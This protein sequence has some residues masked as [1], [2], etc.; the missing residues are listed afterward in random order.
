[1]RNPR[2]LADMSRGAGGRAASSLAAVACVALVAVAG[3][4]SRREL[5]V[6]FA[7]SASAEDHNAARAACSTAAP[8]ASPEPAPSAST[9]GVT[10]AYDVRFRVDQASDR[11]LNQLVQ[12]LRG[13]PGVAGIE[14]PQDDG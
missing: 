5:V 7:P 3:C 4:N 11:D 9:R 1:L 10:P 14:L 13:Q 2:T 8:H 12:C 6:H